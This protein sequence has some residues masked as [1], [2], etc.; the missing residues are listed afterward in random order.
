[1]RFLAILLPVLILLFSSCKKDKDKEPEE[2]PAINTD[3]A[4]GLPD[5]P[6]MIHGYFYADNYEGAYNGSTYSTLYSVFR[7][8]ADNIMPNYNHFTGNVLFTSTRGNISVNDVAFNGHLLNKMSSSAIHY[9]NVIYQA[10]SPDYSAHWK[11]GGNSTF[12]PLNQI[13]PRGL[14]VLNVAANY[15]ISGSSPYS[16]NPEEVVSNYDSLIVKIS[17]NNFTFVK[18]AIA[19]GVGTITFPASELSS[20][21]SGSGSSPLI[22]FYAYNYSFRTVENKTHVFELAYKKDRFI[23]VKP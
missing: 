21:F 16:I 4:S 18:R 8:P 10:A 17:R 1:M 11:T 9:N 19:R 13:V 6:K 5:N 20:I 23:T 15:T 22:S 14:P 7:D 3:M 12:L 2:P